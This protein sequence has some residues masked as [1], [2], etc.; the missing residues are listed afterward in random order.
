MTEDCRECV[1]ERP[2]GD[3]FL[4]LS[5]EG[6]EGDPKMQRGDRRRS[7]GR[8]GCGG[9]AVAMVVACDG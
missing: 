7:L 1:R 3:P 6:V 9:P 5:D 8:A 4:S 2:K